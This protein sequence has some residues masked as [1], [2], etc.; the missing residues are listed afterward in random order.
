MKFEEAPRSEIKKKK[1]KILPAEE[2]ECV[3][4]FLLVRGGDSSSKSSVFKNRQ[5]YFSVFCWRK[6]NV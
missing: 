3:D 2:E 5:K 4:F 6:K 1:V